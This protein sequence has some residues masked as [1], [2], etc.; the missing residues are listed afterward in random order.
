MVEERWGEMLQ[1]EKGPES[2][3]GCGGEHLWMCDVY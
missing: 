1:G 2:A 3:C